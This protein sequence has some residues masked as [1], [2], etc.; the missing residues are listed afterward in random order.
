MACEAIVLGLIREAQQRAYRSFRRRSLL[1]DQQ[2]Q[3]V[4]FAVGLGA[5]KYPMLARDNAKIVTFDWESALD[6]NGQAAPYIQYAHVR[7][8]S[9]LA[10]YNVE[11]SESSNDQTFP[12]STKPCY[13]L[14]PTESS[15]ST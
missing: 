1:P 14:D 10:R 13:S 3:E 2:K 9:I 12:G 8:N 6:F 5:L 4:A 11:M 15:W 7:A